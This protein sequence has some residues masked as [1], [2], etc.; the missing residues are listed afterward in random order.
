MF[1][2]I[3]K[4]LTVTSNDNH[5]I[6]GGVLAWAKGV[7][8]QRAQAA[9]LDTL[10]E[11]RQFNKVKIA[12][13]PKEDNTRVLVIWMS[14]Q[15]PCQY[16][17]GVH[18]LRQCLAYR[19]TCVGCGKTRHFKKVC[20]SR[21]ERAVNEIEFEMSQDSEGEIE[22]V[23]ID[24]AH[25]NKNLSLFTAELEM[26]SGPNKIVI[27]YKIDTGSEGNIMLWHI[28]KKPFKNITED[29]PQKTIKG[30]IKL[31]SYNK[32][33][34]TQLGTCTVTIKF[35]DIK[36]VV[37]FFVVLG[38]G[39]ALLG[40]P[41][42]AVLKIIDINIGSIQAEKEECNANNGNVTESNTTQEAN[43]AEKSCINADADSKVNDKVNGH[44][45]NTNPN[46]IPNYFLSSPNVETDKRKSIKLMWEMHNIFGH[47]FNGIGCFE[48]TFSLQLKPDSK[49]SQVPP[50]H[51]AYAL[52]K[53]FK[54]EVEQLQKMDIITPVGVDKTAE[55]CSSFLLVPKANSK[56][57]LC[58]DLVR[59]NQALIK[60]IHRGPMLNNILPK[61]NNVQ[62]MSIIDVSSGYH[63]LKLDDKLSYL[64]TFAATSAGIDISTYH[65]EQH[66]Q[67]TCSSAK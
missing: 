59:L 7:E 58:L 24:S 39:Q 51:V 41:D 3:I 42:T 19:K 21:R 43:V 12:K 48:G 32:T 56:V 23:I 33:I 16:C 35:K 64:T 22:M 9:M 6:S 27:P 14:Q 46:T 5:I 40:V 13:R 20:H 11:S 36:R 25:L 57:R 37:C 53:P 60:P 63:N 54:E 2:E 29:E 61:L 52:Q 50:R 28:F 67:A 34:M 55:W 4:E 44:S 31:K 38:N 49:P 17:C 26:H 10:T 1:E 18:V 66:Q 30:L 47:V 65:S 62:Y 15:Q 45:N 8:A